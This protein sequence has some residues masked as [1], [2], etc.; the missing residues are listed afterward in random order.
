L[1]TEFLRNVDTDKPC[2][3]YRH[4]KLTDNRL[5]LAEGGGNF[6]LR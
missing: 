6:G 5:Y 2:D 4:E 3:Q 1:G